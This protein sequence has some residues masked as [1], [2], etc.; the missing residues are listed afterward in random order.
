MLTSLSDKVNDKDVDG[1]MEDGNHETEKEG[2]KEKDDKKEDENE[3]DEKEEEEVE[4]E[5]DFLALL[6]DHL[7]SITSCCRC[8]LTQLQLYTTAIPPILL[9]WYVFHW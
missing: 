7:V 8:R 1:H 2:E 3:K 5:D 4:E 6:A 9:L